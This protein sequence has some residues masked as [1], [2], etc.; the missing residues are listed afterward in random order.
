M[1]STAGPDETDLKPT[2]RSGIQATSSRGS[3]GEREVLVSQQ[4]GKRINGTVPQDDEGKVAVE[5]ES[6]GV[7]AARAAA[8]LHVRLVP[9]CDG[10]AASGGVSRSP[11]RGSSDTAAIVDAFRRE[12]DWPRAA[13][14][15]DRE[16]AR[17]GDTGCPSATL[18]PTG[19]GA[20][21]PVDLTHLEPFVSLS[22]PSRW[23]HR[24]VHATTRRLAW[25]RLGE[26]AC[27][28]VSTRAA[29]SSLLPA[30]T[31]PP[32][33]PTRPLLQRLPEP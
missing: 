33:P 27:R 32:H 16:R 23:C 18:V 6:A 7:A 10:R 8:A 29:R 13:P 28:S 20:L 15:S 24:P 19:C 21:S 3:S 31:S 17:A 11:A 12:L 25:F 5:N 9:P 14:F 22:R 26:V 4:H 2:H 1:L 30:A